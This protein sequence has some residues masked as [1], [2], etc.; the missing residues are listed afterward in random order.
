MFFVVFCAAIFLT[1]LLGAIIGAIAGYW[2]GQEISA[3]FHLR[4]M[5]PLAVS[6]FA[7]IVGSV[8]GNSFAAGFFV[9]VFLHEIVSF[10][11]FT[12]VSVVATLF[13]F[14][15]MEPLRL[16]TDTRITIAL[17]FSMPA[18]AQTFFAHSLCK[19]IRYH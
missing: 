10:L 3:L 7:S 16:N 13:L 4:N 1:S 6:L 15:V 19:K 8:L 9:R 2:V 18:L 14:F 17:L 5:T 11:D 12:V